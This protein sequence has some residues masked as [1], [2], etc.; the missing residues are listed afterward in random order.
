M[1][2]ADGE[3]RTRWSCL[4]G[5]RGCDSWGA[6][7]GRG[8]T[9]ETGTGDGVKSKLRSTGCPEYDSVAGWRFQILSRAAPTHS[10]RVN[11]L[12]QLVHPTSGRRVRVHSAIDG[13]RACLR[14]GPAPA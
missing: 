1:G 11:R 8:K 7:P 2:G 5:A 14:P 4:G 13:D 3:R 9:R 6:G 12:A 10:N